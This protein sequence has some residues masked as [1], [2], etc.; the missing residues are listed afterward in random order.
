MNRRNFIGISGVAT[1]I[2]GRSYY[3]STD[4]SNFIR[5]DIEDDSFRKIALGRTPGFSPVSQYPPI[6]C[7]PD[8]V[9][10]P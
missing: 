7:P 8:V 2:A 5:D 3:L 1:L 10:M 9:K 4:K 6:D